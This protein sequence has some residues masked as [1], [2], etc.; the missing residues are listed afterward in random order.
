MGLYNIVDYKDLKEGQLILGYGNHVTRWKEYMGEPQYGIISAEE[1]MNELEILRSENAELK[2]RVKHIVDMSGGE[3]HL[4]GSCLPIKQYNDWGNEVL[5]MIG[6]PHLR[7]IPAQFIN[8]DEFW[9]LHKFS[10]NIT[11]DVIA[12]R[13]MPKWDK[14]ILDENDQNRLD[15][16]HYVEEENKL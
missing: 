12:W 10:S 4:A 15:F 11:K 6:Y 2:D 7:V 5:V 8:D 16:E 1:E 3:W 13:C 14:S 9:T